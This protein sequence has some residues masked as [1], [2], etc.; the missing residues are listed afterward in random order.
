[1][2]LDFPHQK[3]VVHI[4]KYD[5]HS[6]KLNLSEIQK[7]LST[8]ETDRANRFFNVQDKKRYLLVHYFL[9]DILSKYQ[10]IPIETIEFYKD[11]HLKPYLKQK[12]NEQP[13][14]FNLSYREDYALLAISNSDVLG[15]DVEKIKP[16]ENIKNFITTFFSPEEQQLILQQ[17]TEPERLAILFRFWTIK[18]S[19][20]KALGVGFELP[21]IN[22]N[23]SD[24]IKNTSANPHFD[25]NQK[26]YICPIEINDTY[27][28]SF[29]VKTN[30]LN[31]SIFNYE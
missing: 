25:I 31:Y 17:P 30:T 11:I 2:L 12:Q 9:R 6:I 16:L 8:E 29:A 1:M 23:V 4:W 27:K 15:V 20:I 28:A 7:S 10:N 14:Y 5:L 21:L 22:Y 3:T 24:F 18:E 26:W 19:I 13:L